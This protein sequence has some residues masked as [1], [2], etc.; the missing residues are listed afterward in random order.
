M[1]GVMTNGSYTLIK[2][3]K[4]GKRLHALDPD[5]RDGRAFC[6]TRSTSR[7]KHRLQDGAGGYSDLELWSPV[8]DRQTGDADLHRLPRAR[9]SI[10]GSPAA[11]ISRGAASARAVAAMART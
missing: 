1:K 5:D 8:F 11:R 6:E 7:R 4:H 2:I 10:A 3:G 9:G